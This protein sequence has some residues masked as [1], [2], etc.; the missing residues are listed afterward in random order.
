MNSEFLWP[1]KS[2]D[3]SPAWAKFKD[4]KISSDIQKK[5][6]TYGKML[7]LE[8]TNILWF[9]FTVNTNE[10]LDLALPRKVVEM[11]PCTIKGSDDYL[12]TLDRVK[13][14]Y[15]KRPNANLSWLCMRLHPNKT[16]HK[17]KIR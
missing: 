15:E 2:W 3:H 9:F 4:N 8:K 5:N 7:D 11:Y 12:E 10:K 1:D 6:G 17:L 13:F 16:T 14:Y